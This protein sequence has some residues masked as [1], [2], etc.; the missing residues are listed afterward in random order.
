M[1]TPSP[2]Q[3]QTLSPYLD[4]AL[5]MSDEERS[6]WLAALRS[7]SPDLAK[8]L[9]VLLHEHRALSDEGF[10]EQGSIRVPQSSGLAGQALGPY[11]LLSQIGHGG[12]G[13]VWLAERNDGRFERKVAVKFLN[14]ALMGKA[15][16]ERFQREG[17][18]LGRLA[19]PHIAELI[20]AGVS[21]SG[22]PYLILEHIEGDHIDRYCDQRRLDVAGRVRLFL[23]VLQAVAEA[24]ANSIVHRDLK[25][26]NVLVR[27]DGQVKLL[28]FGIA[29][30]LE[31]EEQAGKPQLTAD[32]SRVMTPEYAAPEQLA[33]KT[34]TTATDVYAL[35][36]LLYVLLTGHHPVGV[37]PHT[38]V[39]LVK[40]VL[41]TEPVR[42]SDI[43]ASTKGNSETTTSNATRRA[44]TPDKLSRMLRGD[45]DTI[46]AKALKKNPK[47]RYA[48][49]RALAD[50]LQHYLRQEP[51]T[52]RPDGIAYRAA[53]FIRRRRGSVAAALLVALTLAGA[54]ITTWFFSRRLE[55]LPQFKQRKLTANPEDLRVLNAAISP[56]GKYLGYADRHGIHLQLVETGAAQSLPLP[57]G[58]QAET[59]SWAFGGWYPDSTRF[60]VSVAIPGK[61]VSVWSVPVRG[62]VAQRLADVEDMSGLPRIS[63]DGSSIAY[64]RLRSTFGAREI[65][66]MGPRGESPHKIQT[67]ENQ[68][69]FMDIAWSP[70]GNRIAYIYSRE[71]GDRNVSIQSCDLSGANKTTI[72]RD[73]KLNTFAWIPPRRL[74]Y[75]QSAIRGTAESDNLW[76]LRIDK[77]NGTPQGEARRL[78][79]WSGFSAYGFSAT[80]DGKGLAFLRGSYRV[81]VFVGDLADNG[82][83]LLNAHPLTLDDNINIPMAWTP[84]SR[85]VL[86]SSKR[87]AARLIYKQALE[88]GS[89]PQLVTSVPGMDFYLARVTPDG[90]WLILEGRPSGSNQ[91]ALYRLGIK[92]G[93]PQLIF[94]SDGFIQY[95]CTN[96]AANLCVF[97]QTPAGKN[98]LVVTS[99]DPLSANTKELL[100][101]PIDPGTSAAV[102]ED[103]T[104]QLS[105][106]GSRI[107]I[108][109][110]HAN[111][112]RLVRLYGGPATIITMKG[113]SDIEDLY[114][115]IDSQ[116]LFVSTGA[117]GGG[118]LLHVDLNGQ[119][120]PIWQRPQTAW[121]WGFPSPDGR[122]LAIVGD[123]SAANVWMISNF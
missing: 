45:L 81:A 89:A 26:S 41:E 34:V 100:R 77:K 21:R 15:G 62:A 66:L 98:E 99:F 115:A 44:T 95:G 16:E 58:I 71:A 106:D 36:V 107:G 50:D 46:V 92:G 18:I 54:T 116:S 32:G 22:Q 117:P 40:A 8:Q 73:N 119:A 67:S 87:A 90:A 104:W 14:L 60:I 20:D 75:S 30:L 53:K 49:V 6:R 109:R 55:P 103:Y 7:K 9:E 51:I 65:W 105:P 38:P 80:A 13:S 27:N 17:V 29:K 64:T 56:D 118:T 1:P 88:P 102:G 85:E 57:P 10:L 112:I 74:I 25:P 24:H 120:Q 94:H 84:D 19:N 123:S 72:L 97:G 82:R 23:D 101:I 111:Q 42:P 33:G 69:T 61:P 76:E 37:G 47:E 70:A 86:F 43:V 3:W 4:E 59:A 35:G 39:T 63:P 78:T 110:R 11:T 121:T 83:R 122:H 79:D 5:V 12:M 68:F 48:S 96:K 52:A 28:D 91:I 31:D 113:H 2:D 114:W 108:A 93:D